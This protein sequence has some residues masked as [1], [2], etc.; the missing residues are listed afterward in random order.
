MPSKQKE[1]IFPLRGVDE[2]WAFG[3]QPEGTTPDALNV[4]P[5]DTLD[6][7]ARGGQRWGLSRYYPFLHNGSNAIQQIT[8]IVKFTNTGVTATTTIP[9]TATNGYL[10]TRFPTEFGH[11]IGS[12]REDDTEGLF[13]GGEIDADNNSPLIASNKVQAINPNDVGSSTTTHIYTKDVNQDNGITMSFKIQT[14][15]PGATTGQGEAL[16]LWRVNPAYNNEWWGVQLFFR[17]NGVTDQAS[18]TS[19]FHKGSTTGIDEGEI[20]SIAFNSGPAYTALLA[21]II[22]TMNVTSA[23]VVSI[24]AGALGTETFDSS[25]DSSYD[26]YNRIGFSIDDNNG[27]SSFTLDDFTIAVTGVTSSSGREYKIVPISGGDIYQGVPNSTFTL[28]TSGANAV[29]TSGRIGAQP[30]FGKIYFADGDPAHYKYFENSD[31]TINTWTPTAGTLPMGSNETAVN[32][33]AATPGTPSFTVAEDWSERAA[34]DYILVAGSTANDGFYTI[35]S[36]S[37]SGPTVIT[38]NEVVADNTADGTVQYQDEACKII[39]LYRGRIVMAGLLTDPHNWFMTAAI[40][41]FDINYGATVTATM[42]VAG[43]STNAGECPDII[44]CL[45]PYTDDLMFIGGDHTLWLMRGDPA[46]RG[47]IDNISYQTGISGPD[48]FAFDPNGIFYFFGSGII[49]RMVA[50]GVPEPLSK[51]R[52]DKTFGA[53][54]LT[55]NTVRLA[56]DNVRHGLHI[57]IVPSAVGATTHYFWDQRTDGFWPISFQNAQGPTVAFAFDGDNPDDNALLLGGWDGYIRKIDSTVANDDGTAISSR[58]TY[59]PV[60]VGGSTRNTL[61]KSITAVLDTDSDD[62]LLT[63]Y[64][65]DTIQKTVEATTIRY[66]R[67]LAAGRTRILNRVAGNAILLRLT[68]AAAGETWAIESLVVDVKATGR[69]GKNQI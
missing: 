61:I 15:D 1:L 65:E 38:V 67:T 40:D 58:I 20:E 23:G 52:M 30:A 8:S 39:K 68:N 55:T 27:S 32:I 19:I 48:A 34:G 31:N 60:S 22:F 7:R 42:A 45:A 28:A 3:R 37:G 2:N 14:P 36:T 35:A 18:I 4:V 26:A 63:A 16:F 21:G 44:T 56:W 64:A 53:I 12:Y 33:T 46:D 62:V 54:D 50:G 49:W 51:N 11:Y 43:N 66:A 25:P 47:R 69:T 10:Y 5:F 29:N 24:T 6:S 41:P 13:D 9:F 17:V 59:P 57:F